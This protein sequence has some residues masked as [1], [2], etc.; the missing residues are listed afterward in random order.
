MYQQTKEI[1]KILKNYIGE[2]MTTANMKH[3]PERKIMLE[4][5]PK[6]V[7]VSITVYLFTRSMKIEVA[8]T[9]QQIYKDG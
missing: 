9:R 2:T 3:L 7:Q 5:M 4:Q 1:Q 6:S 8:C